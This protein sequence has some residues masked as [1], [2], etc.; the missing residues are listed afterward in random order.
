MTHKNLLSSTLNVINTCKL[1]LWNK[2]KVNDITV[3]NKNV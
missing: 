1:Q 3:Y 2:G